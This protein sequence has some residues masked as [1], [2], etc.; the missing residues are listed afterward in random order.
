MSSYIVFKEWFEG[1]NGKKTAPVERRIHI[2]RKCSNCAH[3]G[4]R[5]P[6]WVA[7]GGTQKWGRCMNTCG[8]ADAKNEADQ[9]CSSH[10]TP[11]EFHADVSRI[12]RPVFAVV[13]A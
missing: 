13:V 5:D 10:Q 11:A 1:A 2:S 6:E 8:A 7:E 12:E 3:D 4:N 9:W